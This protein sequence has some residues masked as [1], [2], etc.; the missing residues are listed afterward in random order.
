MSNG[1]CGNCYFWD[2]TQGNFGFC[3][4]RSPQPTVCKGDGKDSFLLVWP[5][6]GLDD[7]CADFQERDEGAVDAVADQ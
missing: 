2:Y 1:K 5:Q 3:R 4:A 6:T 7:W